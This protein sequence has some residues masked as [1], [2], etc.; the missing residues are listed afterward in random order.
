MNILEN[1]N[2]NLSLTVSQ[3][4]KILK[5]PRGGYLKRIDFTVKNFGREYISNDNEN[6][7]PITAGLVVDYLVRYK[8][9]KDKNLAFDIPLLG[10]R[11]LDLTLQSPLGAILKNQFG[12]D[13][14]PIELSNELFNDLDLSF[15]DDSIIVACKLTAFDVAYRRSALDFTGIDDI[16]PD[17]KT[18]NQIRE[19]VNRS[20]KIFDKYGGIIDSGFSFKGAYTKQI[21][22]GDADYLSPN[23]LWDMKNI[24]G[25]IDKSH[26][27]QLLIYWRLGMKSNPEKFSNINFLGIINP[28]KD[29]VYLY[30]LS[31]IDEQLIEFVDKEIIGYK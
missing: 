8:I 11:N 16:N 17:E 21:I 4:A 13:F 27:M 5:Q 14:D 20:L 28:R 23:I 22:N 3:C 2:K 7:S 10:V 1:N 25:Y 31:N 24:K 19:L 26:T 18:I 29:E 15:N 9:I 12:S 6:I 30:D